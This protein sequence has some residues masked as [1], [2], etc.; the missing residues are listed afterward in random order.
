MILII[1]L[2]HLKKNWYWMLILWWFILRSRFR[3]KIETRYNL[4]NYVNYLFRLFVINCAVLYNLIFVIGRSVFWQL[5]NLLPIGWFILDY[6]SDLIY[7]LDIFVRY[8]IYQI[9]LVFFFVKCSTQGTRGISRPGNPGQ[10]G[11]VI[12]RELQKIW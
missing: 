12:T 10:R 9:Q 4:V 1:L 5:Q 7:V 8:V 3:P 11:K 2:L 6:F